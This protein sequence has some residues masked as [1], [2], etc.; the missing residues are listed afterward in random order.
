MK[1]KRRQQAFLVLDIFI[2]ASIIV[3]LV[4]IGR[5]FLL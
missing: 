5:H 1:D 2:V 4:I 3:L